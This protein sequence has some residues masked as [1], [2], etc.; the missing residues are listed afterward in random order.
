MSSTTWSS[1]RISPKV[2][3][4]EHSPGFRGRLADGTVVAGGGG[5]GGGL[6]YLEQMVAQAE[7]TPEVEISSRQ[8]NP[9]R[10]RTVDVQD[11]FEDLRRQPVPQLAP[12]ASVYRRPQMAEEGVPAN[13]ELV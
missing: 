10:F 3:S 9:R 4:R 2:V 13:A 6:K 11:L 1:C 5:P 12:G 8:Y 7:S